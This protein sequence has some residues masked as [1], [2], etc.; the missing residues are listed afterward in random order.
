VALDPATPAQS[1][2][3]V[4]SVP[5][6]AFPQVAAGGGW[7]TSLYLSNPSSTP[8]DVLV[9]FQSDTGAN[10]SLPLTISGNGTQPA[11]L[12]ASS[13][14]ATIAGNST[15]LIESESSGAAMTGWAQVLTTS[16]AATTDS[17]TGY[18]VFHYTSSEG[19]E[20]EG[21]VPMDTVSGTGFVLPYES[22]NQFGMGVALANL[23]ATQEATVT[24]TP[25]DE[26]GAPLSSVNLV[27][28]AGGHRS[29]ML[30]NLVP[31]T[32]GK[33]GWIRLSAPTGFPITGLGI[34]VNPAGGL[35]SVPKL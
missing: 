34:R 5:I 25:E 3:G 22:E 6:G 32:A 18:G 2:S 7:K 21:T 15:L 26:D 13:L 14:T 9:T 30:T 19:V 24:V 35:A 20:S 11:I 1:A 8:I 4:F 31:A 33:R 10:L 16:N 27:L 28:P 17:L 12:T 23:S 29:F